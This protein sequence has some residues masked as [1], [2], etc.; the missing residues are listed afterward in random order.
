[1]SWSFHDPR[2]CAFGGAAAIALVL[3]SPIAAQT[4][5]RLETDMSVFASHN[6]F[7]LPG[8]KRGALGVEASVRPSIA[9]RTADGSRYD[10]DAV[11]TDRAYSRRYGN[12]V[13]G[14][15]NASGE[16]RRSEYLTITAS[17]G[18]ARDLAVDL[19][20]SSVEAAADPGSIR[21][22]YRGRLSAII[23]PDAYTIIRPEIG[24]E[25]SG[26]TGTDLLDDTRA[27]DAGLAYVRRID[28]VTRVGVRGGATFSKTRRAS[29][30]STQ[31]LYGTIERQLGGGWT[32]T[33]ELGAERSSS[34][35]EAVLDAPVDQRARTL[36]SGRA[37]LCRALPGPVLCVRG[38]LNSEI[39]GLGGL[40]RRAVAGASY[41][42]RIGRRS[43]VDLS[44]EYQRAMIQGDIVPSFDAVRAT[45]RFERTI[46]STLTASAQVQYLRRRLIGG[47]RIGAAFGGLQLTY[48][49][50]RR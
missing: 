22:A 10:L 27:L 8:R 1:M 18:V 40:Q 32:A 45:A 3:A 11:I 24:Y 13:T 7:L 31:R 30:L 17:A 42:Q 46:G 43:V 39:S 23:S 50:D 38:S 35:T 15:V 44:G 49:M 25:R 16:V 26:F 19:L 34:R 21:M 5:S 14:R 37:D 36:L 47:E 4:V 6:P 48:A 33:A 12:F 29:D 9:V 28:P 41:R 20:T 2:R